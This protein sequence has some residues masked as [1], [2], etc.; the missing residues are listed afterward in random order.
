MSLRQL[1]SLALLAA[2]TFGAHAATP[3]AADWTTPA[4]RK[5]VV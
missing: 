2:L 5:S 1:T 3:K 4:D